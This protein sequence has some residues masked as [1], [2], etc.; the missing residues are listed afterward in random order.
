MATLQKI[1]SHGVALLV[2]VGL[3]ML[4]FIIGDFLNSGSAFFHR[5]RENVGEIAGKKVQI[6]EFEKAINQLTEVYKIEYGRSDFDENAHSAIRNQV[7][8]EYVSRYAMEAQAE[9]LGMTVTAKELTNVLIGSNPSPLI[10]QRRIFCDEMGNYSPTAFQNFYQFIQNEDAQDNPQAQQL[11]EYWAYWEQA[12]ST[13]Q[14]QQKYSQLLTK[15]IVANNLDAQDAFEAQHTTISANYVMLPYTNIADS[16]VKVSS[17]EIKNL[18]NQKK[19]TFY[20]QEPNRAISFIAFPIEPSQED[21][22]ESEEWINSLKEEFSTTTEIASLVNA[23]S[24]VVYDGSAYSENTIPEKYK[25]FAFGAGAKA[26]NVS[27]IT[28]ENNTFSMARIMEC[29]YAAADSVKLRFIDVNNDQTRIDSIINAVKKG[30]NFA[31]LVAN[32]AGEADAEKIGWVTEAQFDSREMSDL[33]FNTKVNDCFVMPVGET[34]RIF[35]VVDKTKATPKAKVAILEH[36][37]NASSRTNGIIYNNA[38]DFINANNTEEKFLAAA[39]EQGIAVMPAYN[40]TKNQESVN[41]MPQSRQIVKWAF[42]AKEGAVSDIFECGSNLIVAALTEAND[43]E[44]RSINDATVELQIE[45][46]NKKKAEMLVKQMA[47]ATSL[48]TLATENNVTIQNAENVNLAAATFG[49]AGNEPALVGVAANAEIG[50]I[51]EP[52]IG[53]RGVYVLQLTSKDKEEA[54]FDAAKEVTSM[55]AQMGYSIP[56]YGMYSVADKCLNWMAAEK[57]EIVDNRANFY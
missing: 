15:S 13:N 30:A 32:Y 41:N 52:V 49:P 19:E 43:D 10:A 39:S 1:R 5:N 54:E 26:G 34:A 50:Q 3:A 2:I 35:Q 24:D 46:L 17:N 36:K 20:K 42:G 4:A 9:Q 44:Y 37:V 31:A 25:D 22:Q 11:K 12:I 27:D 18:Y 55:N 51:T 21:I 6:L 38:K 57:V 45:L 7:W 23:T 29:G 8:Q 48:E 28:F 53:N 40:L 16:L 47:G 14:L 56:Q 33:A